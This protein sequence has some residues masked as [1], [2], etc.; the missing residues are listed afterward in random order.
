MTTQQLK[1]IFGIALKFLKIDKNPQDL[2]VEYSSLPKNI[3]AYFKHVNQDYYYFKL[4]EKWNKDTFTFEEMNQLISIIVHEVR[5]LW[6]MNYANNDIF[7]KEFCDR[8][9]VMVNDNCRVAI[10]SDSKQFYV[11]QKKRFEALIHAIEARPLGKMN[12]KRLYEAV[13]VIDKLN[14]KN[15]RNG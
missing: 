13:H 5:H 6:Q 3:E 9:L 8:G 4:D 15:K 1:M 11:I 10:Q 12:E 7:S 14:E 2:I